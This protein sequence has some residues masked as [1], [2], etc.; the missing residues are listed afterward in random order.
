MKPHLV[1]YPS[2]VFGVATTIACFLIIN[3][4]SGMPINSLIAAIMAGFMA[5]GSYVV[6]RMIYLTMK[7]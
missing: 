2:I 7:T 1:D 3:S 5:F 6:I 4:E